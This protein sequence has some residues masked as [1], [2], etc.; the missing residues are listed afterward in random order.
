[1][2]QSVSISILYHF[3]FFFFFEDGEKEKKNLPL[4]NANSWSTIRRAL[5]ERMHSTLGNR[6]TTHV[7]RILTMPS[8]R[9]N[10]ATR[11]L[12]LAFKSIPASFVT[13]LKK[14]KRHHKKDCRNVVLPNGGMRLNA[15]EKLYSRAT[16]NFNLYSGI[17][18]LVYELDCFSIVGCKEEHFVELRNFNQKKESKKKVTRGG[19]SMLRCTR[20]RGSRNLIIDDIGISVPYFVPIAC[21]QLSSTPIYLSTDLWP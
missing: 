9:I 16:R 20:D 10:S 4:C 13:T 15:R 5:F 7:R 2:H 3:F 21:T 11:L 17:K 12:P 1:M 18:L 14:R 8:L 6:E 19:L